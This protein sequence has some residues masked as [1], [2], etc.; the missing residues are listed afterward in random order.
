MAECPKRKAHRVKFQSIRD[1]ETS[2]KESDDDKKDSSDSSTE[3]SDSKTKHDDE[4]HSDQDEKEDTPFDEAVEWYDPDHSDDET[5]RMGAMGELEYMGAMNTEDMMDR[6]HRPISERRA[7]VGMIKINGIEALTLFD[8]GCTMDS[9]TPSFAE[10]ARI[11]TK[12]LQD[13][14]QLQLGTIGSRAMIRRG[15]Y[16]DL[17]LPSLNARKTYVD[18]VN[19][20]KYDAVIGTP[21]MHKHGIVL[22]FKENVIRIGKAII[23][24]VSEKDETKIMARRTSMRKTTIREVRD[25]RYPSTSKGIKKQVNKPRE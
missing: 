1:D 8:S 3:E 24:H 18:V 7:L 22:D 12:A 2:D 16:V 5:E 19:L 17:E 15:A 4:T 6:P 10:I 21:L 23:P 25:T 11:N 13:N 14:V 20:A 9:I